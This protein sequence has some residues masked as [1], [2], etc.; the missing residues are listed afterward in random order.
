MD[1]QTTPETPAQEPGTEAGKDTPKIDTS[2]I[3]DEL[4]EL[5]HKA[6]AALQQVWESEERKKAEDEIRKAL[7]MAGERIDEVGEELRHSDTTKEIKDQASKLVESV[8]KSKMSDDIRR[9]LLSGLRKL[10]TEL[11]EFLD[12]DKSPVEKAG[13]AASEAAAKAGETAEAVVEKVA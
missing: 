9:G 5:G 8:E 3:L 6:T 2:A 7:K 10:N 1:E 11:T 4:K 12:R 13:E